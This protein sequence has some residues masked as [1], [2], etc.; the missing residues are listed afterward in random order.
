MNA[1]GLTAGS[2]QIQ[3]GRVMPEQ[4]WYTSTTAFVRGPKAV[5]GNRSVP[6]A[7]RSLRLPS[8]GVETYQHGQVIGRGA[9]QFAVVDAIEAKRGYRT[10]RR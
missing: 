8:C 7:S 4:S 3:A 2:K 10:G 6:L 5:L 9:G 1:C